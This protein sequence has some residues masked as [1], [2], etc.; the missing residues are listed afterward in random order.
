MTVKAWTR[1]LAG[2]F[3]LGLLYGALQPLFDIL[4]ELC[5]AQGG[6]AAAISNMV[7]IILRYIFPTLVAFSLLLY[8]VLSSTGKEDNSFFR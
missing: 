7:Y 1:V 2:F 5:A 6:Q 8:G 4:Y 3:M